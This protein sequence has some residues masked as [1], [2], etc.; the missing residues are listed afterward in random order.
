MDILS[1]Y[2]EKGETGMRKKMKRG[3]A[4]ILAIMIVV[5]TNTGNLY[6]MDGSGQ[7]VINAGNPQETHTDTPEQN[8]EEP[9]DSGD[10]G[11]LQNNQAEIIQEG[12]N[13]QGDDNSGSNKEGGLA[14]PDTYALTANGEEEKSFDI[15]AGVSTSSPVLSGAGFT[16]YIYYTVPPLE[17]QGKNYSSAQITVELPAN[18][19]VKTTD[20]GSLSVTGDGVSDKYTTPGADGKTILI[21]DLVNP[22]EI[23]KAMNIS[24]NLTTDNFNNE[25][26]TK[27]K[28]DPL[29]SATADGYKVTG[30]I[31]EESKPEVTIQA[32][33]G[34]N[35]QKQAGAVKEES[36]YY[37]IPYT[38][39]AVN[40]QSGEDSDANRYGRLKLESF[41]I[42]DI[43]PAITDGT[44]DQDNIVGYPMHG[45]AAEVV[46]VTM[47]SDKQQISYNTDTYEDGSIKS[48]TFNEYEKS[49]SD[50]Q[51]IGEDKPITTT[52]TVTVKY[53]KTPYITPSDEQLKEYV[54]QNHANLTYKLLGQEEKNVSD[55]AEIVLGEKETAG[56]SYDLTVEKLGKIGDIEFPITA[57]GQSAKF[58]LYKDKDCTVLANNIEG[59][60]AAGEEQSTDVETGRVTFSNLRKGIYYLKETSVPSGFNIMYPDQ[61][62]VEVGPSI[63]AEASDTARVTDK[64]IVEIINTTS[65]LGIVE[66]QKYGKNAEGNIERLSGAVFVLTNET[67]QK[68]YEA[69]SKEDGKVRFYGIPAGTYRLTE[70]SV[71]GDLYGVS[72]KVISG[73]NV[74]GNQV[75]VPENLDTFEY[76]GVNTTGFLNV[77]NKGILK[78]QKV[79]SKDTNVTLSGAEFEVYGPYGQESDEIDESDKAVT[80]LVTGNEGFAVSVPLE[81]GFYVLKE[82]KAPGG[83]AV[84]PDNRLTKVKVEPNTITAD[85]TYKIENDPMIPFTINKLGVVNGSN[86]EIAYTEEL[87]GAKFEIYDAQGTP[88]GTLTTKLDQGGRAISETLNLA[89][90]TY[91]YE[92][93][94]TPTGYTPIQG[95]ISFTLP[96]EGDSVSQLIVT[97]YANYGQIKII[98]TDTADSKK[99]LP[100]A[101]FAIY[102]DEECTKIVDTVKTGIDGIAVSKLL[103]VS[104]E[105]GTKYWI[106]ETKAPD[107]YALLA[108]VTSEVNVVKGKQATLNV[109]NLELTSIQIK[110]TD[111]KTGLPIGQVTYGLYT[112]NAEGGYDPVLDAGFHHITQIT[113]SNGICTFS[114]LLPD[115]EYY[116]KEIDTGSD[117]VLD[118]TMQGPI[119]TA[120]GTDTDKVTKVSYQNDRKAKLIVDKTTTMDAQ[121]EAGVPMEGVEF[122]LYHFDAQ[123]ENNIGALAGTAT[124][125]MQQDGKAKAVFNDLTP[126]KYILVETKLPEK[127]ADGYENL[128]YKKQITVEAG[129]NQI[130]TEYAQNVVSV[131]NEAV[132]GRLKIEKIGKNDGGTNQKNIQAT[133]KLYQDIT[134]TQPALDADGTEVVLNVTEAEKIAQSGWLSPGT[135]YLQEESVD[136]EYTMAAGP[137]EIQIEKGKT[138]NKTGE[139]AIVNNKKGKINLK[140][141]AAFQIKEETGDKKA[142][143]DLTGASFVLIKKT[144]TIEAD[145]TKESFAKALAD[146]SAKVELTSSAV[147]MSGWLDA[148]DY[149]IVEYKTPE[150]Y[151]MDSTQGTQLNSIQADNTDVYVWNQPCTVVSGKVSDNASNTVVIENTTDQGKLRLFKRGFTNEGILLDGAEFETYILDEEN[152]IPTVIE[153]ESGLQ[154]VKLRQVNISNSSGAGGEIMESGTSGA[155]SAVTVDISPG[156]YYLK[157]INTDK[158]KNGPWYWYNQW[159][160]PLVVEKGKE[161]QVTVL[162]Y[163]MHGEGTKTD[164]SGIAQKNALF[165]V[166]ETETDALNMVSYIKN[167]H[168]SI[169]NSNNGDITTEQ[170]AI[171]EQYKADVKNEDFL[172]Q[173]NILQTAVSDEDGKFNFDGLTPGKNYYIIELLSPSSYEISGE[174]KSVTIKADGT[175]FTEDLGFKNYKLGKFKVVKYTTLNNTNY[176]VEGVGFKVY[177][178]KMDGKNDVTE[179]AEYQES[180]VVAKGTTGADG[181]YTSILL[182]AGK[183]IIFEDSVPE[184]GIVKMNEDPSKNYRII[185]IESDKTNTDYAVMQEGKGFYNPPVKGKFIVKKTTAPVEGTNVSVTFQLE[186]STDGKWEKVNTFTVNA[187]G[188]QYESDFLEAGDYRIY[189]TEASG[190]TLAY[191]KDNALEFKVEGGKITGCTTNGIF[192]G[193]SNST[194]GEPSTDAEINQP[195]VIQ[196]QRQGTLSIKKQGAFGNAGNLTDS[197]SLNGVQFSL[198]KKLTSDSEKDCVQA[199]LLESQSTNAS[200]I[201]IWNNLDAGNYWLKEIS[202]GSN[203]RYTM[204]ETIKEIT[205]QSGTVNDKYFNNPIVNYTTYGKL[206]I[207]KVDVNDTNKALRAVYQIYTDEK[208][209]VQARDI[210]GGLASVT[211]DTQNG[212]GLSGLLKSGEYYLKESA[213]PA[214]YELDKKVYGPYSVESNKIT[215]KTAEPLTDKKLFA[216]EVTKKDT[217]EGS[218]LAGAE[219]GLY[220]TSDCKDSDL[221]ASA[222]SSPEGKVLFENLTVDTASG[223]TAYYVKE[224][225][226]PTGYDLNQQVFE[227][228]IKYTDFKESGKVIY[229]IEI[230]NDQLGKI[231]LKKEG[232]WQNINEHSQAMVAL[233]GAEFAVYLVSGDKVTHSQE[234]KPADTMMTEENGIAITKGLK[235]G[236]YEIVEIKAPAGY[237]KI[238]DTYWVEVQN[239]ETNST[240]VNTPIINVPNKGRFTIE[241]YDGAA[242]TEGIT[243]IGN[244]RAAEFKLEQKINGEFKSVGGENIKVTDGKYTSN[245]IQEGEYRLIETVAPIHTYEQDGHSYAVEFAL[246]STPIEFKVI[247]G[248]TVGVNQ[249]GSKTDNPAVYNSPLGSIELTKQGN[250][251]G[252]EKLQ[253]AAFKL[254]TDEQCTKEV[255]DSLKYT[256]NNGTIL[257]KNLTPG[258]YWVKEVSTTSSDKMLDE[259]GYGINATPYEVTIKS[260]QLLKAD[261]TEKITVTNKADK[262]RLFII[263]EDEKEHNRLSGAVFAI[264][265]KDE[266]GAWESKPLDTVTVAET[267]SY[268]NLLPAK[269]TGTEYKVVEIKAPSGYTL[270]STLS[271]LEQIITVYPL[272]QPTEGVDTQNIV[273]FTNRK[274]ETVNSFSSEVKKQVR[275]AGTSTWSDSATAE[276]SLLVSDY[277][278]EFLVNQYG[279]GKND[280]GASKFTVTDNNIVL[281]KKS[282]GQDKYEAI[283]NT[284]NDY[285]INSVTLNAATNGKA[286]DKVTAVMYIQKTLQDKKNNTWY[287]YK[288]ISD[289]TSQQ[290]IAFSPGQNLAVGEKVIGVK[291]EYGNVGP[292][293]KSD[294]MVLNVTF[295]NRSEWST[296]NDSEVRRIVNKAGLEWTSKKTDE[297]GNA[298]GDSA[299][300]ISNPVYVTLPLY[301]ESLPEVSITNT[302]QN[303][304]STYYSG[305]SVKYQTVAENHLIAGKN[306]SLE[307]PVIS[308]RLPAMTVLNDS[309]NDN[310]YV[311]GFLITLHKADGTTTVI[312]ASAYK[313]ENQETSAPLISKGND[314]YTES[315]T[316]RTNQYI[317]QFNEDIVLDPGDKMIINYTGIIS[318]EAKS[319]NGVTELV[320]P[321]YLSSTKKAA[322][323]VENPLG[324]SFIPYTEAQSQV[325]HDNNIIDKSV[326]DKLQYLNDTAVAEVSDSKVV[327]LVKYIGTENEEGIIEWKGPGQRAELNP[328][329]TYY[330][331]LVLLNNS[332]DAISKAKVVDIL[333]FK[334]DTY[335]M[336]AGG[337]YTN[338]GTTIP[339][340]NGFEGITVQGL[341]T[342][343]SALNVYSTDHNWAVRNDSESGENGILGMMYNRT[344]DFST[345]GWGNGYNKDATALGFSMDFGTANLMPY[346]S[347]EIIF[348]V[349]APGYSADKL[350]D[351]YEKVIQNSAMASVTRAGTESNKTIELSDRMEPEKVTAVL[352]LPTGSIGDYVWFDHDNDGIQ[353]T[354]EEGDEPAQGIKV[355]LFKKT[356]Y[357]FNGNTTYKESA[358]AETF[359]DQNG[360]YRFD[361]LACQYLKKGASDGSIEPDDYVGGEYY[362]YRVHFEITGYTSTDRYQGTDPSKDSNIDQNGYTE[363]ITLS[364]EEGAGGNLIGQQNMTI[365]AGLVSPYAL[366]DYVWLDRNNDGIQGADEPGVK[367]VTVFLYKVNAEGKTAEQYYAR[368]TTD[369]NG[370][371]LF[372]NLP[373]GKYVIEFDISNLRKSNDGYT[374]QYDF[375]KAGNQIDNAQSDAKHPVDKDGRIKRT[376]VITL[377]REALDTAAGNEGV[378]TNHDLRWDAGLVVYSAIG[379]FCFDDQDY[380]DI[381]TLNIPLE[382]TVVT[383]YEKAGNDTGKEIGTTTV[384]ADGTYYFDH[385]VFPGERQTY[386]IRFDYPDGYTGV[387]SNVGDNDT[388]D[389]DALYDN[390]YWNWEELGMSERKSGY[391]EVTLQKDSVDTTWDAGARKYSTI[392]DYVWEDEN[393]N[394]Q[395]D[396]GEAPVPGV[397]IVLQ[398]RDDQEGTW[399]F[400][401]QT[402]TDKY[403]RYLFTHVKSSDKISTQYRVV[404][405]LAPE[406][407]ITTCQ[408]M[409]VSDA[410][411]SDAIDSYQ[412]GILQGT[413][414]YPITGGYVTRMLKPGYGETDLTWD[415]GIIHLLSAVGDYVW[416]DDDYSGIQE[417]GKKAAAGIPVTLEYNETAD[418]ENEDAWVTVDEI[419]TDEYGKYLFDNL[420]KGYYRVRFQVPNGYTITKY[421]QTADLEQD[422]D[423]ML[424]GENRWFYTKT[425]YLEAGVTDLSW[426][427]GIYKPKIRVTTNTKEEVI[428]KTVTNTIKKAGQSKSG[429]TKTGDHTVVTGMLLLCVLSGGTVFFLYCRKKKNKKL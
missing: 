196:N 182:P 23:G 136:A 133:F 31:P 385:L 25:N 219:I 207:K 226:A 26:D 200:G 50:A 314:K 260:G 228:I 105:A 251:N 198:Y 58:A 152:G 360:S 163:T 339:S 270:D 321:A 107:G 234:A 235:A 399:K 424:R 374:Y 395:Q 229:P 137:I 397:K 353:G 197:V 343:D 241:K 287:Q 3:I 65:D 426:D 148:G 363:Y 151:T 205:I 212:I 162:N 167:K 98:K 155:G 311:N 372:E 153:T 11:V 47:G 89:P 61:L 14:V 267:G 193:I 51:N 336:Q 93:I 179:L 318:Y 39:K 404:F 16:Y 370:K 340:G 29:L 375:T 398:S 407:K 84:S 81:A 146:S 290:T 265:A 390:S 38:I 62:Q 425:F 303:K 240:Y 417:R 273:T 338:R 304:K 406:T 272:H 278:A 46:S 158:I 291:V 18:V 323:S 166:F 261:L 192:T 19:H 20:T 138:T 412:Y 364:V 48:I 180:D 113:N 411:N 344:V 283:A 421:A 347:Y 306:E 71:E 324:L 96:L 40:Q 102:E 165:G 403:G 246:D 379:G 262:G 55:S 269:E 104:A 9:S 350:Q 393:K 322:S 49:L 281:E 263:K 289:L 88:K 72:A 307:G 244:S 217:K 171:L 70:K 213:A 358:V 230:G 352:A 282:S 208:C 147:G 101:E 120:K 21:I 150:G 415:A 309:L 247:E 169:Y 206:Q 355:T 361:D 400:Y 292:A 172:A 349:K 204:D 178:A 157:E 299:S 83:Y 418:L 24:I 388:I 284:E 332:T 416:Y 331:K 341:E 173:H 242:G 337:S 43:L 41:S 4:L 54:L 316:L 271:T 264:Y 376:D 277:T 334:G 428:T 408:Q 317:F 409:G 190:L 293:F 111:S 142:Y 183:Y 389:S 288:T 15:S 328:N 131:K 367:D 194:T 222:K 7:E 106:K 56:T 181:F 312:P 214:G 210:N 329:E 356:Y 161:T 44:K 315:G 124:T 346:E 327:Q 168:I 187:N 145:V 1:H 60:K 429:Q 112:K 285:K 348:K 73:I 239:N 17:E 199:N 238:S 381:H 177:E 164:N 256:G 380:N 80:T 249:A 319:D 325:L 366:G 114:G 52:Y 357:K 6:A 211:T 280:I 232:N 125:Q 225:A 63:I 387:D 310:G 79:S 414:Q 176:A 394:G 365:D 34:W 57:A 231:E 258:N 326:S 119:R 128:I 154:T 13:A 92:E 297:S 203:T 294:G 186:K 257:W 195:M 295:L 135:Y 77:S 139:N 90:G 28:L 149:W 121:T 74:I 362:E 108:L 373:Q 68:E 266:R 100:G 188:G 67:N 252:E 170:K 420:P 298:T 33:D 191:T 405:A 427:A 384:G 160:G 224:I 392:G 36:G 201:A 402:A 254:Y 296:V 202:L 396:E 156:I 35:I 227:V 140:K 274:T 330:Y 275:Q 383:L 216:I 32:D 159:S 75:T 141:Q 386:L 279:N 253:G 30:N 302:I 223:E 368:T 118:E 2:Y 286:T 423:A 64:G 123:A 103:P 5:T 126:G 259:K 236:W 66:F 243:L 87:P 185:T 110:K 371:Y 42:T 37:L 91:S 117:Y 8:V 215:D 76:N 248:Q 401:A 22:L 313:L 378:E 233:S 95:K 122:K 129:D 305:D 419:T 345:N 245:P 301:K 335:V 359:T 116:V 209:T 82:V 276:K 382:G 10:G 354:K 69:I 86:G 221:L 109:K 369:E 320:C 255:E 132:K 300:V 184:N 59:T 237:A 127:E 391:A 174:V 27:I 97:N 218:I 144:G 351:Y 78:I 410:L 413:P 422:S 377:T 189:E 53:P 85:G 250:Q 333:P 175:G 268:S 342:N 134:C 143:Y 308:M 115:T 12:D 99:F 220:L 94:Y 130:G 45:G